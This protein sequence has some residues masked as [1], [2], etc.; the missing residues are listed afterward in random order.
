[1][2]YRYQATGT[3]IIPNKGFWGQL[4][5]LIKVT[6]IVCTD[7]ACSLIRSPYPNFSVVFNTEKKIIEK[8]GYIGSADE[9]TCI[10]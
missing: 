2:K 7:L 5:F 9:A 8:L 6:L 4:P 1:M 10:G 3:D